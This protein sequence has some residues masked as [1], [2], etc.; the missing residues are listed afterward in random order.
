MKASTRTFKIRGIAAARI[1]ESHVTSLTASRLVTGCVEHTYLLIILASRWRQRRW[2][3]PFSS[4]FPRAQSIMCAWTSGFY[5][6]R[7]QNDDWL[8]RRRTNRDRMTST[9]YQHGRLYPLPIIAATTLPASTVCKL[10]PILNISLLTFYSRDPQSFFY[11]ED[12]I[13][14]F[15]I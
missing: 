2:Q 5:V 15:I 11:Q 6:R 9:L 1:S 3:P 8:Q 14:I 4:H 7:G 13:K 12:C 10:Q